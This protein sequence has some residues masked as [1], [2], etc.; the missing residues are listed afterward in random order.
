ML[1]LFA[2][3]DARMYFFRMAPVF[4][5]HAI[6]GVWIQ[7]PPAERIDAITAFVKQGGIDLGF[8]RTVLPGLTVR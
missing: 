5:R 8:Y 3:F 2:P 1:P 4:S 6:F 7:H